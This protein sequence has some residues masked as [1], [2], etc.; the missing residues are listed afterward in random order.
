M[1]RLGHC[2][3]LL[4]LAVELGSAGGRAFVPVRED[5]ML[6]TWDEALEGTHQGH[7]SGAADT[8]VTRVV[9]LL[10]EMQ[11]TIAKEMKEDEDLYD[12]LACWCANNGKAKTEA[13]D[14]ATAAIA[15][16]ESSIESLTAQNAQLTQTIAELEQQLAEDKA[17]MDSSTKMRE[18]ERKQFHG[19]ELEKIQAIENLKSAIMVLTKH[20]GASLPQVAIGTDLLQKQSRFPWGSEHESADEREIDQMLEHNGLD[21]VAHGK[22]FQVSAAEMNPDKFLSAAMVTPPTMKK[23]TLSDGE[24]TEEEIAV[25]KRARH[26]LLVQGGRSDSDLFSKPYVAT[27]QILGILKQL[28]EELTSDLTEQQKTEVARASAFKE[29]SESKAREMAAAEEQREDKRES[30]AMTKQ[31]LEDAKE[32]LVETKQQLSEDQKFLISLKKTCAEADGNWEIRRKA[33]LEEIQAVSK[34]INFLT[35]DEAKDTFSRTFKAAGFLQLSSRVRHAKGS[36]VTAAKILRNAAAKNRNPQLSILASQVELDAF[37]RVK[38][39]MDEMVAK[40]KLQQADEVKKKDWCDS[41]LQSN[42]MTTAEQDT[43]KSNQEVSIEDLKSSITTLTDE[44]EQAKAQVAD[45]QLNLQRASEERQQASLDFQQT[46]SDQKATQEILAKALDKLATFYDKDFLQLRTREARKSSIVTHRHDQAPPVPQMEYK[47]SA[48]GSGVM[49]MIEKL[50]YDAKELEKDALQSEVAAQAQY[51]SLVADTNGSVAALQESIVSKSKT[52]SAKEVEVVELQEEME[53][54]IEE[55]EG[56]SKYNAELHEGCDY[57][58]KNFEIRQKARADEI[59]AIQQA[60][61]VL[62]GAA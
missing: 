35:S 30:L 23:V 48:G 61:Q 12:K 43:I 20:V 25:L 36:Q 22:S 42:S 27:D 37:A 50:I 5:A 46:I 7:K 2:L 53:G 29:L 54:T 11:V 45:Q 49:S 8:P 38:K 39:I 26:T 55:L 60:K 41:E 33:R 32:D 44:L 34:T 10:Q 40:L 17:A 52:K 21:R 31:Q 14:G 15:N 1:A 9:K 6:Q 16:L 28:Q 51:E 13:V 47:K 24:W 3:P 56:L 62:N 19:Q 57:V 4:V 18:K 58:L 59:E